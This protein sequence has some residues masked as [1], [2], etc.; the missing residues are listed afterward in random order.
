MQP[1]LKHFVEKLNHCL[2]EISAPHTVRERAALL[3]KSLDIPKQQAWA[4]L[5]GHQM[6]D[7]HLLQKIAQEFEVDVEWLCK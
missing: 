6:P 4:L 2:D 3:S 1:G 5:E 7:Q